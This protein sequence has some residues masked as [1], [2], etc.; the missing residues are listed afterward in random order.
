MP[1]QS[2]YVNKVLIIIIT[3]QIISMTDLKG[4]AQK[5]GCAVGRFLM[6][7]SMYVFVM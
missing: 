4:I 3:A 2:K 7:Q 6:K 1:S 5:A